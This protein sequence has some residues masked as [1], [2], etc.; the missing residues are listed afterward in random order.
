MSE[1]TSRTGWLAP[2]RTEGMRRTPPAISAALGFVAGVVFWHFVGFW[3]FL[4]DTLLVPNRGATTA[5]LS[6]GDGRAAP[7]GTRRAT[8]G[9]VVAGTTAS[10]VPGCSTLLIDRKTGATA[11]VP[12]PADFIVIAG[13]RRVDRGDLDKSA[14]TSFTQTGFS[15]AGS[16]QTGKAGSNG[17]HQG[18]PPG[19]QNAPRH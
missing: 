9:T 13:P 16:S 14:Q 10:A 4:S 18:L 7:A 2:S 12:C 3:D 6:S 8:S 11:T 1:A 17:P 19:R 15:Q 5:Q